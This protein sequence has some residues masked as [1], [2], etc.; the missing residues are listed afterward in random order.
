MCS[1]KKYALVVQILLTYIALSAQNVV[2]ADNAGASPDPS[3]ML[4]VQ[5]SNK[6]MLVPRMSTTIREGISNAAVGLLVFD[7]TTESFWFNTATGWINL[8]TVANIQG[9]P[10]D[11]TQPQQGQ[12]MTY[13]NGA[14]KPMDLPSSV[15][16]IAIFEE[17]LP[18]NTNLPGPTSNNAWYKRLLNTTV[19]SSPSNSVGLSGNNIIFNQAGN[20]LITASAPAWFSD[21]HRLC[22]RKQSDNAIAIFGTAEFA[23]QNTLPVSAS[24]TRS[25]ING[26]LTVVNAG[27]QY[28][29][30]HHLLDSDNEPQSVGIETHI[31]DT[32]TSHET[33]TQ[34]LIQKL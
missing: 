8:S 16:D 5:A 24:Q 6:G 1:F 19:K 22:L 34:I 13:D 9:Q 12:V 26:V 21:R 7:T 14:W 25:F 23:A 11:A 18:W 17:R 10:V 15:P 33:Y 30:D 2:I 27:E 32:P 29:L 28:F 20:Y 4:D 31:S 3:A